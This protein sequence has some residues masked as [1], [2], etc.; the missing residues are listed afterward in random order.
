M[1]PRNWTGIVD[2]RQ[3]SGYPVFPRFWTSRSSGPPEPEALRPEVIGPPL[4]FSHRGGEVSPF[5][6]ADQRVSGVT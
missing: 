4:R 5:S 1:V 2:V 6:G 3:A